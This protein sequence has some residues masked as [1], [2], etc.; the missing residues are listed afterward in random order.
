MRSIE[1]IGNL[2]RQVENLVCAER[3]ALNVL[4]E[5]LAFQ[6]LHRDEVPAFVIVDVVNGADV[7][8]IQGRSGLRFALE[9]LQ[10]MAV[11]RQLFRQELQGDRAFE[12][13][14]FRLID[15]TH[16]VG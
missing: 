5:C 3:L 8:V 15:N 7:R 13:G 10:D 12:F 1:T 9:S 11:S 14:V 6:E 2:E 4:L 16:L